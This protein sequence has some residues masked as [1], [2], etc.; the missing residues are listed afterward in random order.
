MRTAALFLNTPER[1]ISL[2]SPIEFSSKNPDGI[3]NKL[4]CI[5][6]VEESVNEFIRFFVALKNTGDEDMSPEGLAQFERDLNDRYRIPLPW[7]QNI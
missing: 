7:K 5:R 4:I 6:F 2:I 1:I 3:G